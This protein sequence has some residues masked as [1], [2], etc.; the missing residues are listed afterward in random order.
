MSSWPNEVKKRTNSSIRATTPSS[1]P[2]TSSSSTS[3]SSSHSTSRAPV[4]PPSLAASSIAG[5]T[6]GAGKRKKNNFFFFFFFC[7]FAKIDSIFF[8][9]ASIVTCPLDVVKTRVQAGGHTRY[10]GTVASLR[11]IFAEEGVRGF[12]TTLLLSLLTHRDV[13]KLGRCRSWIVADYG[14]IYVQLGCLLCVL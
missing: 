10:R 5:I 9:V 7:Q 4:A 6:A 14:W 1:P 13:L 12:C 2:S 8:S 11:T 3:T